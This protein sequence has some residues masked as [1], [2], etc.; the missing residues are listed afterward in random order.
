MNRAAAAL[1]FATA[2]L[3]GNA[4]MTNGR[5]VA[6][7]LHHTAA[8]A[9]LR[10]LLVTGGGWHDYDAQK[11]ILADG[12]RARVDAEITI[13][14]EAGDDSAA[15]ITRH[16]DAA[17]AEAFDLVVY[18]ICFSGVRDLE[19]TESIVR[20][21]VAHQVPAVVIHCSVHSYNY[22]RDSPIWSMFI[23]V[24]SHRHQRQVPFTVE[25][26]EPQHP[27]MQAVTMPWRTPQGELYE[28]VDVH[29]TATPL[30]HAF[31]EGSGEN[32]VTIWTNRFAGVRVFGTTIGHHNETMQT[33]TYLD[34]IAAGVLWAANRLDETGRPAAGSEAP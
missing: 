8:V 7:P 25:A 20:A 22:E 19:W 9:P 23:G 2:L 30:A 15:R 32:Q 11:T 18:N 27:I 21:H 16:R 29:P 5:S 1:A 26:L 4:V 10:V 6:I 24:E 33:D 14:H 12:I 3:T 31:G 28:I 34:L 13:D 17:W